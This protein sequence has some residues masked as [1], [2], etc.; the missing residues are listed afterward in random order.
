MADHLAVRMTKPLHNSLLGYAVPGTFRTEI[1]SQGMQSPIG[2]ATLAGPNWHRER[3][4]LQYIVNQACSHGIGH[5]SC[6]KR[7]VENAIHA[8]ADASKTNMGLTSKAGDH[9]RK[10]DTEV[11]K[12]YLDA[13]ELDSLNLIVSFYLDF[14]ELQAKSQRKM[15]MADWIRKLDDFLKLSERDILTHAGKISREDALDKAHAEYEKFR[16]SEANKPSQV[17]ADFD[18]AMRRVKQIQSQPAPPPPSPKPKTK[19]K[20]KKDDGKEGTP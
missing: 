14:A 2:C 3:Q 10:A 7:S 11:A 17:E 12:N 20:R 8:R 19:R 13:D 6:S 1:M 9:V 5:Q 16:I 15:K 18:E 4:R